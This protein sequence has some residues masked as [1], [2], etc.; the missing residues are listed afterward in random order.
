MKLCPFKTT[1]TGINRECDGENCQLWDTHS[2]DCAFSII[3]YYLKWK[4]VGK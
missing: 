4:E 3:A 2:N 1:G